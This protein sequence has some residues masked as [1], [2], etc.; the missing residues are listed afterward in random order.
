MLGGCWRGFR[1]L[2]PAGPIGQACG[3]HCWRPG[4]GHGH[5]RTDLIIVGFTG[6]FGGSGSTRP[7]VKSAPESTRPWVNSARY[8]FRAFSYVYGKWFVLYLYN[9]SELVI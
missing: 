1:G 7:E 2:D 5:R 6:A 4:W 9:L 8:I 3:R